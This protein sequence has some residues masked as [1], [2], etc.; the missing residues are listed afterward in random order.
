MA[1]TIEWTDNAI[2]D[3]KQIVEY[4]RDEW[5]VE[6]AKKFVD[7]IDS[8]LDLLVISPY[9]GTA[10]NKKSGVREILVTRQ[11]KLF[12]RIIDNRIIL[13]DFFDTRRD[14]IKRKY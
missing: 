6:S 14:P 1:Y 13:L 10:S 7:K 3:L 5:S 12:Y 4:L 8:W 9:I 2:Q 11:N